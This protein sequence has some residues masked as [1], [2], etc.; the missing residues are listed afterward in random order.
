MLK[1]KITNKESFVDL[2]NWMQEALLYPRHASQTQVDTELLGSSRLKAA[3]CLAIYQ[4]SYYTRLLTCMREQFPALCY[5]LGSRVFDEFA[6][7]YL[8]DSPS[9]SYTLYELGRRFPAYLQDTRPDRELPLD[10]R[11]DWIDFMV[12][13]AGF[14]RTVFT[15]FDAPGDEGRL[16]TDNAVSDSNLALQSCFN[17]YQAR[18]PVATYYCLVRDEKDPELPPLQ[19]SQVA[20]VRVNYRTRLIPLTNP[21]YQFLLALRQ[22]GEVSIALDATEEIKLNEGDIRSAW[23]APDGWRKEWLG[24][25]FFIHRAG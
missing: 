24:S 19:S 4:R 5:A 20:M 23:S 17:I 22:S 15:M 14:E 9:D 7:Q 10:E 1:Q 16:V 12:D 18:F 25:G 3:D 21:Q 13:L 6:R 8:L 2:Q 11:E